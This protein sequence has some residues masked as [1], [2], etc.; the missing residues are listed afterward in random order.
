MYWNQGVALRAF[1]TLNFN[2]LQERIICALQQ[3]WLKFL[4]RFLKLGD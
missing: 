2:S 3:Y 4:G 1:A